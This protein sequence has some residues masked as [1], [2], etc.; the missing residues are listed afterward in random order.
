MVPVWYLLVATPVALILGMAVGWAVS[1][2]GVVGV[3][4]SLK[5][6]LDAQQSQIDTL[7]ERIQREVKTRAGDA[8]SRSR[9]DKQLAEEALRHLGEKEARP[10]GFG[11]RPSTLRLA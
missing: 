10:Q 5:G 6:S 7:A 8:A 2:L 9:S 11:H 1:A 3:V 4:R